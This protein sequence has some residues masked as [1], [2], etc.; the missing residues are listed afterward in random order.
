MELPPPPQALARPGVPNHRLL[1]GGRLY[2]G[3]DHGEFGG[4]LW[5]VDIKTGEAEQVQ[6]RGGQGWP[7][8][9]LKASPDG[10]VWSVEG[11]VHGILRKGALHVGAGVNWE[12]YC[13]STEGEFANWD[14][15]PASLDALAFDADGRLYVLSGSLGLARYDDGTWTR[16]TPGW[17]E[18]FYVHTLLATP[19]G[20]A[21]VGTYDAGI[22]LLD[23]RS[24]AIRRIALKG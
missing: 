7:V 3:F 14:L 24:G 11:L 17:P 15:P 22:L 19:S 9:C 2:M 10:R 13:N 18:H 20:V 4:G 16:L 6:F 1:A 23:L 5:S 12:L 8:R 21:V